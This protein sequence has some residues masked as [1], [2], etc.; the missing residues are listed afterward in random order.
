MGAVLY[1]LVYLSIDFSNFLISVLII[2]KATTAPIQ[3][4]ISEAHSM[5]TILCVVA[6]TRIVAGINT[7]S[8]PILVDKHDKIRYNYP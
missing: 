2:T 6:A 3:S 8:T 5:E 4:A 7:G 1:G